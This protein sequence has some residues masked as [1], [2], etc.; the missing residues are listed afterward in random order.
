MR[1]TWSRLT[2]W[3]R[4]LTRSSRCSTIAR[5]AV[6]AAPIRA[7]LSPCAVSAAGRRTKAINELKS[8][9]AINEL[10][11][12]IV[13]TPEHLRELSLLK[14]LA[15]IEAATTTKA[16]TVEHRVTVLTLQSITARIRFLTRQLDELNPELGR[17]L[18]Q[19]PAGPALLA[20]PGVGP[21]WLLDLLLSWPHPGR[22]RNEAAFASLAGVAPL[23]ASIG[24]EVDSDGA[25]VETVL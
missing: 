14:Q 2:T 23:E 13:V 17:L 3:V 10:K 12:L 20:Q 18:H 8:L 4:V 1:T 9:K 22:V 6:T 16:A 15:R 24:S 21:S 11:S 5:C 25:E 7:V 19:H